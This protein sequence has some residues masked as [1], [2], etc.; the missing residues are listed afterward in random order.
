MNIEHPEHQSVQPGELIRHVFPGV[1]GEWVSAAEHGHYISTLKAKWD[2]TCDRL[3]D[4]ANEIIALRAQLTEAQS[5][6]SVREDENEGLEGMLMEACQQC[7]SESLKHILTERGLIEERDEVRA[8]L[9]D[10]QAAHDNQVKLCSEYLDTIVRLREALE[11]WRDL[12]DESHGVVGF[13]LNGNVAEW[14]EFEDPTDAALAPS[15]QPEPTNACCDN[16]KRNMNGGC[17][18][19]GDPSL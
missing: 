11:W 9:A 18:S 10:S 4:A 1:V 8:Q 7:A 2:S 13:H 14:G 16:E 5:A 12:R 3:F 17:D 6:L 19:C 15:A